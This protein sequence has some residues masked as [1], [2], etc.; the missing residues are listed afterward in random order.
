[1]ILIY[2]PPMTSW[3]KAAWKAGVRIDVIGIQSHMH[4]GYWGR[5]KTLA[6][7]ERF[8][9]FHLPIHFTENTLLSGRSCR[10]RSLT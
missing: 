10:L 8:E 7:L 1:M 6:V 9:R 5:E 4:Q 2:R 3:W